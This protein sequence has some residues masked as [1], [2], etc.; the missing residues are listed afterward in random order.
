MTKIPENKIFSVAK[1]IS[2]LCGEYFIKF[3]NCLYEEKVALY[4]LI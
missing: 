3:Q 2:S 1:I 4:L